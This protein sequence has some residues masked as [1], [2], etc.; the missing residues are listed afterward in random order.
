[1]ASIQQLIEITISNLEEKIDIFTL[2]ETCTVILSTL[3]EEDYLCW[4]KLKEIM[5]RVKRRCE[6]QTCYNMPPETLVKFIEFAY[7][8]KLA[9]HLGNKIE[10]DHARPSPSPKGRLM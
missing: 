3:I 10:I 7:L 2:H 9:L 6:E 8:L 1:M 5:E 4:M